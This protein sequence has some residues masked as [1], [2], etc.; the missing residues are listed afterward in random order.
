MSL[1]AEFSGPGLSEC[2]ENRH[3][4]LRQALD[5]FTPPFRQP[6]FVVAV[7]PHRRPLSR[8]I[9]LVF[10][11]A[12][13]FTVSPGPAATPAGALAIVPH[14]AIYRLSLLTARSSSPVVDV[15]GRMMFQWADAC[16]AWTVEQH[17]RMNF[18][19]AQGDE[20]AMTTNYATWET[21]SGGS[22]RFNVRK[23]VN[24][25]IDEEVKG[26]AAAGE[27]GKPGA[28]TLVKPDSDKLALPPGTLFPS[29][30][31]LV[32]LEQAMAGERFVTRSVFDGAETEGP[33]EI[34]AVIGKR[35]LLKDG[36][37]VGGSIKDRPTHD[38]L[39]TDAKRNTRLLSGNAWPVRLAFFPAK[40]DSAAPEYEMS[41]LLL[42]N[43][44]A[45]TMQIDYG[46]FVV[47]A[48]LETLEPLP[49][50]GC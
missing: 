26:E 43:G 11:A 6:R 1:P 3:S 37:S 10:G 47:S 39:L 33:T 16:D 17:F 30:H 14:R 42:H 20:V 29:G 34:S 27:H 5:T 8:L 50:S 15:T 49:K 4:H 36:I 40:S 46:D 23:T 13:L 18:L 32:L 24:G 25:Q 7:L 22:Y 12:V 28:V 41:L 9:A 44:I 45:E 48:V 21:K 19:Y 2:I 35:I 31:T 38:V